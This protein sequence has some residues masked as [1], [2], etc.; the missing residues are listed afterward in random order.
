[1]SE[2]EHG[3][4]YIEEIAAGS[5]KIYERRDATM[6]LVCGKERACLIDT[7]YGL[8]DLRELVGELTGLPVTVVNTHGHVDHVLGNRWF[9]GGS[10]RV[11]LHP[12]DRPLY[13]D[14][15]AGFAELCGE[16]WVRE[17][18]GEYLKDI[19]PAAVR[20]PSPED[21]REGDVIDLG[22]K[23]LEVIE[24]PGHTAG[25]ILLLDRAEKLC[26]SGDAIIEHLWLFLE[27]S[28][29]PE[30]Y[31][32]SLR[33]AQDVLGAAGVERIYDGH[34]SYTPLTPAQVAG[35]IAD[36][37]SILA[38]KVRGEPFAYPMGSGVE[39]RF[40]D[41]SILCRSGACA[42]ADS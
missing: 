3:P 28:L 19:D 21:I 15:Q 20:F 4:Y 10:G 12:A 11:Y 17:T 39:Y 41:W 36:L 8:W 2:T 34:F 25:S 37:E 24:T 42:R 22:G 14:L 7:A 38:G 6:Y 35:R 31:L 16:P 1:M 9:S 23:T 32:K 40:D 33:H 30:V 18:F 27:E 5:Y 29:S 13:E 26:Y